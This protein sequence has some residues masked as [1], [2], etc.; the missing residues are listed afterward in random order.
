VYLVGCENILIEHVTLRNSPKFVLYPSRCRNITIRYANIYNDWWAQNG[1]GI[2]ISA[3]ERVIIYKCNVNV[4][5]DA[6][7]MKSSL[8]GSQE[9]GTVTNLSNIIIAEC[10]VYHGHGGF[11][12]GSNTDGG[13]K[14]IFV[15]HCSFLGTDI[16]VRVKSNAGSGG[17]V[18]DIFI[19][20]IYMANIKD[21]AISFNT[22]YENRPA[23]YKENPN[24]KPSPQDKLPVFRDF[25][26]NNIYCAGA[27]TAVSL[28]GLPESA[29]SR[30]FLKDVT[31]S[32]EAGCIASHA[33]QLRFEDVRILPSQ[34]AVYSLNNA[35][36]IN[37][38]RGF[39]PPDAK[40]FVKAH[41]K[42]SQA[43]II[44]ETTLPDS[45]D[46]FEITDNAPENAVIRK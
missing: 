25:H 32:A 15:S 20:D 16:G 34:D 39:M 14:N 7:C 5:D 12:I 23:G 9:P 22:V 36:N 29:I 45:P 11:V 3:C 31:I 2:D 28:I 42:S 17:L 27:Q 24:K 6:I 26:F 33:E 18:R 37:I 19:N 35:G 43:I 21:A 40:V 30:M 8:G 13:M 38:T 46:I 41:G 4:G 44:S 1:D 10:T